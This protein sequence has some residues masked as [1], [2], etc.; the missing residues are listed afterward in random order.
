MKTILISGINGFLGS[1]LAKR[2]SEKHK[3]IGL[4]YDIS[5]LYRL[6]GYNFEVFKSEDEQLSKIFKLNR[7]DKIIHTA[8]FYGKNN[9]DI[10]Q[11][12]ETNFLLPFRLLNLA[13]E[14][15]IELFVNTDTVLDRFTSPYSLTK[16]QFHDWLFFRRSEIRVINMKLEHFYGPGC[17]NTNFISMMTEKM[18]KNEEI[19]SL[20]PGEQK[21]DFIYYEDV[22]AAFLL[23]IEKYNSVEGNYNNFIVGSGMVYSIREVLNKIKELTRSNTILDF[24]A[25]PYRD[26][27]LMSSK[28]DITALKNLGWNPK[29]EFQEGIKRTINYYKN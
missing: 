3:I 11:I 22:V 27:E 16:T 21:R 5:N 29:I 1:H 24:G 15:K 12:A 6:E 18:I 17:S 7:I 28:S 19:I 26:N 23:V 13:I 4:E 10:Q 9:E 25:L 8:T 14:Y 20:T 2:L